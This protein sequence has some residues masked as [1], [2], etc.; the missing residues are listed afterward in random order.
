MIRERASAS[1]A[2]VATRSGIGDAVSRDLELAVGAHDVQ[3]DRL[4][5]IEAQDVQPLERR[6]VAQQHREPRN[7]LGEPGSFRHQAGDRR[8]QSRSIHDDHGIGHPV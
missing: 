4:G 8:E 6:H 2:G 1:R 5:A 7:E 3:D